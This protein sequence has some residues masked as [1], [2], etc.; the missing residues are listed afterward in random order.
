MIGWL[1]ADDSVSLGVRV[2]VRY[3]REMI[4]IDPIDFKFK[5]LY[6]LTEDAD[7]N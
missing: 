1:M 5:C 4:A 2:R 7:Y 3:E 6:A